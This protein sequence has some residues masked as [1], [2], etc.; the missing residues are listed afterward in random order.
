[1]PALLYL[2][3]ERK[4]TLLDPESW[5]DSND[6]HYLAVYREKKDLKSVLVLCF[7]QAN[8]TYHHWRVFAN[9]S[10]GVCIRFKRAEL[11]EIVK[12]QPSIRTGT[13]KYLTLPEM[14]KKTPVIRDLPFL[15]RYAFEQED[16]FRIVYES[17]TEKNPTLDIAIPLS[18]IER[19]TLSPWIPLALSRHVKRTLK[20]IKG[21]SDLE[22]ARSTLIGNEEWKKLGEF[23]GQQHRTPAEHKLGARR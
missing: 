19:I 22:I 1:M 14:R 7:T 21:C 13:V 17:K 9:G 15:K 16:E 4:I 6:S 2:L 3:N 5:D 11:L 20:S 8:E 10:S 12:V 18:C 23:A